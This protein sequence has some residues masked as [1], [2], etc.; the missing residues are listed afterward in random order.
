MFVNFHYYVTVLFIVNNI[1]IVKNI[2]FALLT[3]A[4]TFV[5]TSRYTAV[6]ESNKSGVK[7]AT[8]VSSLIAVILNWP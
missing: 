2:E 1:E 7:V 5:D 6:D 8:L 3:T 4:I